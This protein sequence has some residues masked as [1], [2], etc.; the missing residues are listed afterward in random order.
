MSE[1]V[2]RF[3]NDLRDRLSAVEDRLGQIKQRVSDARS[4][5]RTVIEAKIAEVKTKAEA[6]R[7]HVE[8][9]KANLS[10]RIEEKKTETASKIEE[11]K[12][13]RAQHKL[14]KRADRSEE[15]AAACIVIAADT[16]VEAELATLEAIEARL[17]SE[18]FVARRD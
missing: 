12:T 5:S 6:Q 14:E 17:L 11:W 10:S 2:D 15:Y 7:K 9:A 4:E 18:E 16:V 8:E 13:D 1:R 3:C